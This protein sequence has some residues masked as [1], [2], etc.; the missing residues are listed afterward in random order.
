VA[1]EAEVLEHDANP[2]TVGRER[3]A[4]RFAQFLT[5]QLDPAAGRPLREVEQFEE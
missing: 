5:E 2:A 4:R 3:L 1:N